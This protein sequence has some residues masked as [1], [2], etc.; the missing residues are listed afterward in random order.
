MAADA[1]DEK[2]GIEL[3]HSEPPM[4]SRRCVK[5]RGGEQGNHLSR[6]RGRLKRGAEDAKDAAFGRALMPEP[7]RPTAGWRMRSSVA[8]ARG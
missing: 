2:I 3:G 7:S 5:R 8:Q 6:E 4:V 1:D